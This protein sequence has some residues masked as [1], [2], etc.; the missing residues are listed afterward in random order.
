[1]GEKSNI[2]GVKY[3][4]HQVMNPVMLTKWQ[5]LNR[6][7]VKL[8]ARNASALLDR[9]LCGQL[10]IDRSA[11]VYSWREC[12]VKGAAQHRNWTHSLLIVGIDLLLLL[13]VMVWLVE[14]FKIQSINSWRTFATQSGVVVP[15]RVTWL[16]QIDLFLN[17]YY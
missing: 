1:M 2:S 10:V 4:S 8:I 16:V 11:G 3:F 15:V 9:R 13:V 6:G 17:Y 14:K 12:V 7:L 5:T